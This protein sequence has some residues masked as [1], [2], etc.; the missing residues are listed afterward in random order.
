MHAAHECTIISH[1]SCIVSGMNLLRDCHIYRKDHLCATKQNWRGTNR[2]CP[3]RGQKHL[4]VPPQI[5]AIRTEHNHIPDDEVP[6]LILEVRSQHNHIPD[7]EAFTSRKL[8]GD[9][10]REAELF[11]VQSVSGKSLINVVSSSRAACLF[12]NYTNS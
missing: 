1:N 2:G 7:D 11:P 12:V 3:G 6:P 4:E 5:L 8:K 10:C 9:L